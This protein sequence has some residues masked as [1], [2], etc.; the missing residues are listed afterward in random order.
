MADWFMRNGWSVKK[1]HRLIL[2]SATWQ[3]SSVHPKQSKQ[4]LVDSENRLLWRANLRRVDFETMRDSLLAVS[5]QLDPR[6]FGRSVEIHEEPFPPRRTLY[7]YIDRQNLPQVF[8]TFDFASPQAHVAQRSYT[9]VS[10]QAL[11]TL[12]SPFLLE[13]SKRIAALPG[14][15]KAADA[16][17]VTKLYHRIFAREPSPEEVTLGT[18]FLE[19]QRTA[20]EGGNTQ[21]MSTWQYGFA[22]LDPETRAEPFVPFAE[23]SSSRWQP[24]KV[25]PSPGLLSHTSLHRNGGHPGPRGTATVVRWTA[26]E[27]LTIKLAGTLR[28]PTAKGDGVRARLVKN[29]TEV[30]AEIICEPGQSVP[31]QFGPFDVAAGETIDFRLDAMERHDF[32]SYEWNPIVQTASGTPQAWDYARDFAGPVDLA[33]PIEIYA[34]ALVS[35]NEFSFVD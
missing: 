22:K 9:T 11:F 2:T 19:N 29:G 26:P 23:W 20:V 1:L 8:T 21:T 25:Y 34:Q 30:L 16:E 6:L 10:T 13:Q 31:T 3:Q 33:T 24:D 7:A 32:D 17:A 28:K 35:T 15:A 12:N 4:E 18:A 27:A 14:I 5:G